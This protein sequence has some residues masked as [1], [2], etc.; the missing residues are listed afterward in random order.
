MCH[1]DEIH[2]L[3]RR[4]FP[5]RRGRQQRPGPPS[6]RLGLL[7][8]QH[9]HAVPRDKQARCTGHQGEFGG[10]GSRTRLRFFLFIAPSFFNLDRDLLRTH[11][12]SWT[13]KLLSFPP[14][15]RNRPSPSAPRP[16]RPSRAS[17]RSRSL[18]RP[19]RL[20]SLSVSSLGVGK[21]P[22][23]GRKGYDS[24]SLSLSRRSTSTSLKKKTTTTTTTKN[25]SRPPS[26]TSP[27]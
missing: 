1:V 18:P 7:R 15:P 3:R 2:G 11:V 20:P 23:N 5:H 10:G 25:Q 22:K 17:P 6:I 26:P 16:R 24:L 9:G 13:S 27:A 21:K 12:F 8:A 19:A 14:K 4:G